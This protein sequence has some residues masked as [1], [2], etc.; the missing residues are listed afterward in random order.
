LGLAVV[1]RVK[2]TPRIRRLTARSRSVTAYTRRAADSFGSEAGSINQ[3]Y[4][5]AA[6]EVIAQTAKANAASFSTRIPAATGVATGDSTDEAL[7]IVDG[8][9]APNALPF[10]TGDRHPLWGVWVTGKG[11]QP[12][13]PFLTKAATTS[14]DAAMHVYAAQID[15]IAQERGYDQ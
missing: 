3:K 4:L 6:A 12:K 14:A 9:A 8:S 2:K 7:V 11:K 1:R 10:E 5:L 13:R 15:E